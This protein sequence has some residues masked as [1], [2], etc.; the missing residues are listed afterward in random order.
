MFDKLQVKSNEERFRDNNEDNF[1][2]GFLTNMCLSN[3]EIIDEIISRKSNLV[4][5]NDCIKPEFL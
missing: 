5:R 3:D 4:S 1:K 2:Q